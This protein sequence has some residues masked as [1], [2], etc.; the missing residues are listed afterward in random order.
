[1]YIYIYIYTLY[2][3]IHIHIHTYIYIYI[4]IC[5]YTYSMQDVLQAPLGEGAGGVQALGLMSITII[6]Q[7]IIA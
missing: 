6:E 1:M 3:H 4:Y 5:V 7:H 2:I